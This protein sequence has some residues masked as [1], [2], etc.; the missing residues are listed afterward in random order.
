MPNVA[1]Y[2]FDYAGRALGY[3]LFEWTG[4]FESFPEKV[5]QFEA[6]ARQVKVKL[7]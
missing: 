1:W 4:E 5:P 2:D 6:E 3:L 7:I